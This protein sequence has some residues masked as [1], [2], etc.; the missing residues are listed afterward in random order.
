MSKN[1][2]LTL[3]EINLIYKHSKQ[4]CAH[5]L[6]VSFIAEKETLTVFWSNETSKK[7]FDS[8]LLLGKKDIANTDNQLVT[9]GFSRTF[10]L[11]NSSEKHE[12]VSFV[13]QLGF[14]FP[15]HMQPLQN[16]LVLN[17]QDYRI[18]EQEPRLLQTIDIQQQSIYQLTS[19]PTINKDIIDGHSVLTSKTQNSREHYKWT[20]DQHKKLSIKN[21]FCAFEK[22]QH[23]SI[24]QKMEFAK[25]IKS[26]IYLPPIKK[27]K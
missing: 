18:F 3:D 13:N 1:K 2:K 11:Q 23:L 15:N 19:S 20:Q 16:S 25:G 27:K 17:Y 9:Q 8:Q 14:F 12:V 24:A 6:W 4:Q 10:N 22:K 26:V 21:N 7:K 5:P